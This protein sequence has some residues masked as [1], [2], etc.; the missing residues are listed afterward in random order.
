MIEKHNTT[1]LFHGPVQIFKST[2]G[3]GLNLAVYPDDRAV[4]D[5]LSKGAIEPI[6]E[7]LVTTFVQDGFF[8][9]DL[10]TNYGHLA[11]AMSLKAGQSGE[12]HAYDATSIVG[13][14][15]ELNVLLNGLE[16]RNIHFYNFA[17][18]DNSNSSILFDGSPN[19]YLGKVLSQDDL[20]YIKYSAISFFPAIKTVFSYLGWFI[21]YQVPTISVDEIVKQHGNKLVDFLRADI[22]GSE[23]KMLLGAQQ[24]IAASPNI[25]IFMEWEPQPIKRTSS[26]SEAKQCVDFLKNEK[27]NILKLNYGDYDDNTLRLSKDSLIPV[28]IDTLLN[29]TDQAPKGEYVLMR[30]FDSKIAELCGACTKEDL[31]IELY[32]ERS[33]QDL[34]IADDHY[35]LHTDL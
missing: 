12:V 23:C 21:P 28:Q 11:I 17:I 30:H 10:G 16:N 26:F 4:V 1:V 24:T 31:G 18:S 5:F 25:I 13:G 32:D 14:Y 9:L 27:F 7:S 6:I 2:Y 3:T 8:C 19:S 33:S 15:A 20:A 22:E 29:F 35:L 34:N